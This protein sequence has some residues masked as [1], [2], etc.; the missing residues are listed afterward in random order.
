M[1]TLISNWRLIAAAIAS[2]AVFALGW[3]LSSLW[4]ET[5]LKQAVEAQI[6]VCE[7]NI[8][9][10]QEVENGYQKILAQRDADTSRLK[11]L[12][13]KACVSTAPDP[14]GASGAATVR[15]HGNSNGTAVESFLDYSEV[16][17]TL[18]AKNIACLEF[19]KKERE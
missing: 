10:F 17:E 12:Y 18:R 3:H 14:N 5:R 11:R 2:I 7:N 9:K 16:A 19:L 15:I 1:L 6:S 8:K 4:G 13:G